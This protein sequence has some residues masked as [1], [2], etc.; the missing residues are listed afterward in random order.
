[1]SG[2]N[3]FKHKDSLIGYAKS[4]GIAAPGAGVA[5]TGILM[6]IGGLGIILGIFTQVALLA[7]VLFLI[8][9][10]F[11]MHAY[12]KETDPAAKMNEQI[13]FM[14]NLALLGATIMLFFLPDWPFSL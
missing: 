3:H 8:P 6:I 9:T 5:I 1:M 10:T 7:I 14:K 4:K 2:L 13:N 12:W 11:K